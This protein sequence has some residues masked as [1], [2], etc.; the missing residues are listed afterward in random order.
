MS[1][2]T[3]GEKKEKEE[4]DGVDHRGMECTVRNGAYESTQAPPPQPPSATT[5]PVPTSLMDTLVAAEKLAQSTQSRSMDGGGG[6]GSQEEAI[7][8][9]LSSS[10]TGD[11]SLSSMLASLSQLS[12]GGGGNQ[13]LNLHPHAVNPMLTAVP[14]FCW[15]G[16]QPDDH[17]A[18]FNQSPYQNYPMLGGATN[19]GGIS[20]DQLHQQQQ[21]QASTSQWSSPATALGYPAPQPPLPPGGP[22][23]TYPGWGSTSQLT[24]SVL[25]ARNG[26]GT[27]G[28]VSQGRSMSVQNVNV[29]PDPQQ[30]VRGGG[31]P[32][33][34]SSSGISLAPLLAKQ[35]SDRLVQESNR[36]ERAGEASRISLV[37]G[38][39]QVCLPQSN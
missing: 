25:A 4:K 22:S 3:T 10:S 5:V 23:R 14:G 18:L 16:V 33:G 2:T 37:G 39:N 27:R 15:S 35:C 30:S 21:Q 34:Y 28:S 11:V 6:L 8:K 7:K 38:L 20:I 17:V 12:I 13:D 32:G 24:L 29:T 36:I 31:G 26:M 19:S 1:T 9:S